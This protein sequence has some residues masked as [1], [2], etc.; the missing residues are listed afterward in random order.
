LFVAITVPDH[1]LEEHLWEHIVK[2]H[3]HRIFLW[4]FGALLVLEIAMMHFNVEQWIQTNRILIILI[5]CLVGLIPES[6]P[7]MIFVM[8]FARGTIPFSILLASSIVQDGHGMLPMLAESKR[9]F[10]TVKG[11]N[12]SV[13]I[14]VGLAGYAVGL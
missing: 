14:I 9:G 5:A 8:L 4:T 10:V 7:H 2:K 6:G 1:F 12:F 3:I 11:I 13:G